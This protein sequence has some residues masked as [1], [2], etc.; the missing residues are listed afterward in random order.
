MS[1]GAQAGTRG[2]EKGAAMIKQSHSAARERLVAAVVAPVAAELRLVDPADYVAFIRLEQFAA[3][4]D[5]VASAAELYLMPGALRLG[6]GGEAHL[7]WNGR[8]RIAL[9]LELRPGGAT[10]WFT[11]HLEA[12]RAGV[13][14][15]YVSF[16]R[17][18]ADPDRNTQFLADALERAQ[19]KPREPAIAR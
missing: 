6:P 13:E 16:E 2:S 7:D 8:P 19:I 9:D 1:G 10:V 18:D 5:L 4:A 15:N 17:P 11:L 12:D 3:L 14:V